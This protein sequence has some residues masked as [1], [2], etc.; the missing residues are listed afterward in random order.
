MA[1]GFFVPGKP[2][3]CGKGEKLYNLYDTGP[4]QVERCP[5]PVACTELVEVKGRL[6][7]FPAV[8]LVLSL[9]K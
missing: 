5:E 7:L 6:G 1:E 9:S 4:A 8:S 3:H 2:G